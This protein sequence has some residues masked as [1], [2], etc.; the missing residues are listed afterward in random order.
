M[1][2]FW[3]NPWDSFMA[4]IEAECERE[5]RIW[6]LERDVQWEIKNGLRDEQTDIEYTPVELLPE[7]Q[8]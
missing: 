5:R 6:D 3:C 1:T 4:R 2:W 7:V 8:R